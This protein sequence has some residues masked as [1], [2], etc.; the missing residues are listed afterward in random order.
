M[1]KDLELLYQDP[2]L[3]EKLSTNARITF[4]EITDFEKDYSL[5]KT[6]NL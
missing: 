6:L 5:I 4:E 2:I 3:W 1:T